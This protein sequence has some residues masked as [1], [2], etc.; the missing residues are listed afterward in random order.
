[1]PVGA[2]QVYDVLKCCLHAQNFGKDVMSVT[3]FGYVQ[4]HS[5]S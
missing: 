3:W 1:M 2:N 5:K 4:Y